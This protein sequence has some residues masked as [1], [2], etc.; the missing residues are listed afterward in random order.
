MFLDRIVADKKAEVARLKE[1]TSAAEL[2]RRAEDLP[3]PRGFRAALAER[4]RREI[5]LIAEIKKASPSKGLIRPDFDP[6][7]LARAYARAGA[8]CLSVLTDEPYFQGSNAYLSAVRKTVDLP[9]LRKDFTIDPIQIHETR[10]IGADAVLLIAAILTKEELRS[11]LALARELGLDALVEVHSRG[12]LETAL[13]IGADLIGINNRDLRTFVTDLKV[14]E[15]LMR[16]VPAGA[17]VVSESGIA[18]PA[19]VARVRAAGARAVL[20]GE[21]FMRQADVAAA[22]AALMGE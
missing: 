17:F 7:Q 11:F 20:V 1:R 2:L 8:D 22:V 21:H 13:E 5:G 14:T 9:I 4:A 16:H 6:V 3:P 12:E 15:E 19:D 18:S 10:A